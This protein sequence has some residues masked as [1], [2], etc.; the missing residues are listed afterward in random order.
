[1][2]QNYV[3]RAKALMK[4]GVRNSALVIVPLA[5]AAGAQAA[6]IALTTPVYCD[7]LFFTN[8]DN[9]T[10]GTAATA[11]QLPAGGQDVQGIEIDTGTSGN[12]YSGGSGSQTA[13]FVYGD[14][15][16]GSSVSSSGID[17]AS[18]DVAY[19]FSLLIDTE[20]QSSSI[21]QI[22]GWTLTM[23]ILQDDNVLATT[24]FSGSTL[25]RQSGGS[26]RNITY[27]PLTGTGSIALTSTISAA[28]RVE[29]DLTYT[30]SYTGSPCGSCLVSD[31]APVSGSTFSFSDIPGSAA[32]EPAT[33][34]SLLLGTLGIFG[35]RFRRRRSSRRRS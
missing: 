27:E 21:Y 6:P 29:V 19:D 24:S 25:T 22:T 26:S 31:T 17:A 28:D 5:A 8:T 10:G 12:A 16:Y 34:A 23:G 4:G 33:F 30:Y 13:H 32:P 18:L 20:S 11:T 9:C 15:T 3:A 14:G 2:E 35:A 1:M 7:Y